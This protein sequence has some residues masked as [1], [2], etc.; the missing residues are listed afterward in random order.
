MTF[1]CACG[2]IFETDISGDE[3]S[4]IAPSDGAEV[5]QGS[6]TFLWNVLDGGERYRVTI[7]SPS[8]EKAAV[9][10]K[11]TIIYPDSL[12]LSLGFR[13][14]LA[15]GRYQWSLQA[16]NQA[17]GSVRSVYDLKVVPEGKDDPGD[18]NDGNPADDAGDGGD[19]SGDGN[20]EKTESP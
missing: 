7:V 5:T 2:D 19:G 4:V 16:F 6:V 18:G 13:V 15:E 12:S 10:V 1:A 17:Y 20:D 9:A 11:D 3:V 14:K 8:F